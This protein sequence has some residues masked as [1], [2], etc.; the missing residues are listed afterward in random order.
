LEGRGPKGEEYNRVT[1]SACQPIYDP[2]QQ[3]ER[4]I[5]PERAGLE[6]GHGERI[7]FPGPKIWAEG[8]PWRGEGVNFGLRATQLLHTRSEKGGQQ[9][10]I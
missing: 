4:G 6:P 2:A 3:V 1:P 5:H 10:V 9:L 7:H 8:I